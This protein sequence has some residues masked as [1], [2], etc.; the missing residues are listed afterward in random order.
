MTPFDPEKLGAHRAIRRGW[1]DPLPDL[2]RFAV[3]QR[4]RIG[5]HIFTVRVAPIN[6]HV[7][8]EPDTDLV[9]V[10]A[11]LDNELVT[12]TDL[13]LREPH[14]SHM[15]SYLT[16]K[17]TEAVVDYYAPQR[18]P[19]GDLNPRLGC[20]GI[21]PDLHRGGG[22][23]DCGIALLVGISTWVVG[24]EPRGSELDFLRRLRD[25]VTES[26]AY[27]VLTAQKQAEQQASP[28]DL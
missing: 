22:H 28:L 11:L 7:P 14:C 1:E 19:D 12:C 10:W 18:R 25:A 16:T 2:R 8:L 17:I 24:A 9:H 21:R 26:L 6:Q 3:S 27:W 5:P 15:W 20:W 4:V 13:K 23:D